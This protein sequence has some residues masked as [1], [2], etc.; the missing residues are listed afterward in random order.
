MAPCSEPSG[1]FRLLFYTAVHGVSVYF[2]QPKR[3]PN[4]VSSSRANQ[5][6]LPEADTSDVASTATNSAVPLQPRNPGQHGPDPAPRPED[7]R[8]RIE[9]AKEL[10]TTRVEIARAQWIDRL[11][12]SQD[13][14]EQFD[15]AINK[16]NT[17]RSL[18]HSQGSAVRLGR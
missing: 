3:I 12:L 8:A 15:D 13:R 16:M 9:E 17:L 4:S 7:L 5:D 10:W 11:Q 1:C 18:P 2:T 6:V 14:I